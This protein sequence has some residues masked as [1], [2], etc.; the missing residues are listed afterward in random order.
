MGFLRHIDLFPDAPALQRAEP[1]SGVHKTAKK[2]AAKPSSK[3]KKE[4]AQRIPVLNVSLKQVRACVEDARA[5]W[6]VPFIDGV[7]PLE[8]VLAASAM[9]EEDA[10]A[11]M[12][13][14]VDEGLVAL[15]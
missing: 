15:I 9:N 2:R 11:G 14:L 10:R 7:S 8:R 5:R 6:L 1:E 13:I 4:D 12:Q 3:K